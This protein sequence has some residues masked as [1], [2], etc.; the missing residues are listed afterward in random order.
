MSGTLEVR[1]DNQGLLKKQQ[2]FR[3][4]ALA[5][6]S[7]ALHSEWD[8]VISV[9][10]LMD[11]FPNLPVL[12]H[13]Y[14][15]QDL[16]TAYDDL[17][18]DAQMNTE[19]D[20]LATKELE[21]FS[22]TLHHVPFDPES[23]VMLSIDGTTV[24]RR[25]ETTIRTKARLPALIVYYCDRLHWDQR[26]FYAVDWETFGGVYQKIK[27]RNFITKFC[28]ST[29]PTGDR[30]HRRDSVYDN[31]CPTCHSPDE[32]DD[33]L[34]QCLSPARRAWRSD[35]LQ[36]LLKPIESFL[37]PVLLDIIQEG[38]L[39]WFRGESIDH[40]PYPPRYQRLL[41]QQKSIGWN[42]F[43]RGKFSEEW[44]YLQQQ[45]CIRHHR[46]MSHSQRQWL[47]K[48][49]RTMWNRIHTLWL[50][51]ND[52]RHGRTS[53][54]K[55]QASLQQAHR[56]IRSL[57]LLKDLV[58]S[59]DRDL[60]YDDVSAHLQQPL[61]ELNAWVT[62]H[63]GLIAYSVRVA[64]LAARSNTKPITEHFPHLRPHRKRRYKITELL[65]PPITYRNTKLTAFVSVTR[66]S[67]LRVKKSV[68]SPEKRPHLRQRSLHNLW[69]DPL[70]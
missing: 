4:F 60:F 26:S 28:F 14:G 39:C 34:L 45:Y 12:A 53:K 64:K 31:R 5:K 19:A 66:S 17:P 48:L 29:L 21:E 50:A 6:Y 3:K 11:K 44:R 61:R 27:Q 67:R 54:A 24:T 65:P 13:V 57:Y 49:L 41:K 1:F 56:T 33:H 30:L 62:T 23:R 63:Q 58:L 2:S 37:D 42:N 68:V 59:E 70:G 36:A 43:L 25:L 38:L 51:R 22:T 16:D 18:L 47:S 8:A 52:D 35:L 20:A 32:T 7:A 69:P 15:H 9:Y 46:H 40:T 55:T 10:N